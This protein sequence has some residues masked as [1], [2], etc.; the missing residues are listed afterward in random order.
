MTREEKILALTR[1]ELVFLIDSPEWL[2]D[3]AKFFAEGGF[4]A[5]TDEKLNKQYQ[6]AID[7]GV[8]P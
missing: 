8:E 7:E 4:N 5:Y 2:N 1:N 6:E 3:T